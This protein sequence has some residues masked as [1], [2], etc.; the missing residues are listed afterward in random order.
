MPVKESKY[1]EVCF[2][3]FTAKMKDLKQT[4]IEN[5]YDNIISAVPANIMEMTSST[6]LNVLIRLSKEHPHLSNCI[7]DCSFK[8]KMIE[9]VSIGNDM[10]FTIVN[11]ILYVCVSNKDHSFM[12]NVNE[13]KEFIENFPVK[14]E[15]I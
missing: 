9:K 12:V 5:S 11:N 15:C 10:L 13:V 1:D 8:N 4:L 3:A 7:E 6:L 14:M 2:E